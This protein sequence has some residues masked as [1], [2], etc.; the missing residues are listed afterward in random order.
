MW[1]REAAG[2]GNKSSMDELAARNVEKRGIGRWE[3]RET[4]RYRNVQREKARDRET[5][6]GAEGKIVGEEPWTATK[7][8]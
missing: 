2:E 4:E 5:R 7:E 8:M 3:Q 6:A 1:R